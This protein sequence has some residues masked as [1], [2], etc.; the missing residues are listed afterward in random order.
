MM[1]KLS[2]VIVVPLFC[3]L[4]AVMTL[5]CSCGGGGGGETGTPLRAQFMLT[6]QMVM[7]RI[8]V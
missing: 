7:M 2:I 6:A 3:S 4:F 5:V 8:M 1:G